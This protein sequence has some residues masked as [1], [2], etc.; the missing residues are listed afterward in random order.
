MEELQNST[1]IARNASELANNFYSDI[2]PIVQPVSK[3]IGAVLDFIS[4]PVC[5]LSEKSKINFEKRLEE[6]KA[7]MA[8]VRDE[9]KCEVHPEIGVPIMQ[10]LHYTTNDE[11]A[12]M[13][14]NLLTTASVDTT[15]GNAHPAFIEYIKQMSPDEA[16]IVKYL[17]NKSSIPHLTIRV[18]FKEEDK[19]FITP[20]ENAVSLCDDV[21]MIYPQNVGVYLSNLLSLGIIEDSGTMHLVDNSLYDKIIE[22]NHLDEAK[23]RYEQIPDFKRTEDQKGYYSVTKIGRLFIKACCG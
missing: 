11:I 14:T 19:G 1:E 16:R 8:E 7:K 10:V 15:A 4:T 6:Y 18:Y 17:K 13:F 2:R 23:K 20:L 21:A 9:N 22:Y 5:F 3:C 12:D